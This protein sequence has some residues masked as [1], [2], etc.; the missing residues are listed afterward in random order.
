[1]VYPLFMNHTKSTRRVKELDV[2]K[3]IKNRSLR[4]KKYKYLRD[5]ASVNQ[6]RMHGLCLAMDA[7]RILRM[8]QKNADANLPINDIVQ[9]YGWAYRVISAAATQNTIVA[10]YNNKT[11]ILTVGEVIKRRYNACKA[12]SDLLAIYH[13]Y[14]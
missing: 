2:R 7:S 10:K 9:I 11:E 5:D 4:E 13:T 6:Q 8:L 3:Y 14:I 12:Y 1:M